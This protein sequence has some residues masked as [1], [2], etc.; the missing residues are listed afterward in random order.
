MLQHIPT[1]QIHEGN[2]LQALK[3]LNSAFVEE[4]HQVQDQIALLK[5]RDLKLYNAVEHLRKDTNQRLAETNERIDGTNQR[6][7]ETNERIDGTNQRLDSLEETVN[8]RFAETN[9]RIDG[10]NERLDKMDAKMDAHLTTHTELLKM[11][12]ENT[13]K[14]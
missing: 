2:I 11:L 7:D 6:L 3:L 14:S 9:E 13:R 5:E 1:N 4:H 12:V 8:H 10:T